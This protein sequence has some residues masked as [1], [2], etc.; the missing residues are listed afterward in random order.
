MWTGVSTVIMAV[1]KHTKESMCYT[2]KPF[3]EHLAA[4]WGRMVIPILELFKKSN[5]VD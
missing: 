5:T 3:E 2:L 1:S 4:K